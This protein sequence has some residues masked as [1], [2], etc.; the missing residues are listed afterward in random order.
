MRSFSQV[1]SSARSGTNARRSS[2]SHGSMARSTPA[3]MRNAW[4]AAAGSRTER[5]ACPRA[6]AKDPATGERIHHRDIFRLRS[7]ASPRARRDRVQSSAGSRRVERARHLHRDAGLSKTSDRFRC[8]QQE[9]TDAVGVGVVGLERV[10]RRAD[11]LDVRQL[12]ILL[13]K[14]AQGLPGLEYRG[15]EARAV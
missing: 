13:H 2:A 7:V 12:A 1:K 14:T 15:L 11:L 8:R 5:A 4:S 6:P 3:T 9:R 10:G